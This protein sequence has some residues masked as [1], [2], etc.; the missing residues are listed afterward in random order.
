MVPESGERQ[1]QRASP[2]PSSGNEKQR[3]SDS[4]SKGE[5]ED[6]GIPTMQLPQIPSIHGVHVSSVPSP[7]P[8]PSVQS[9]HSTYSYQSSSRRGESRSGERSKSSSPFPPPPAFLESLKL[10]R[11]SPGN[12]SSKESPPSKSSSS[13]RLFVGGTGTSILD[14]LLKN[15][16]NT[17]P[18]PP[19]SYNNEGPV[20]LSCNSNADDQEGDAESEYGEQMYYS[21]SHASAGHFMLQDNTQGQDEGENEQDECGPIPA[22][23]LEPNV[24][25][26]IGNEFSRERYGGGR[27]VGLDCH[28]ASKTH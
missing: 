21:P 9:S 17:P 7:S 27:G 25:Y 1:T 12:K 26:H 3:P 6:S 8:T 22:Q 10:S 24:E 20:N 28:L 13:G 2:S 11:V 4:P 18:Q 14:N 23:L 15:P 19:N 5:R 16:R